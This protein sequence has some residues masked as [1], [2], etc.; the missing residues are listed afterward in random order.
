MCQYFDEQYGAN[1]VSVV[2]NNLYGPNDNFDLNTSHVIPA[3]IR[4][5]HTAKA[6]GAEYVEVWG[7][8]D[9]RR[10]FLYV[11]DLA[12]AL[13]FL[14]NN[15]NSSEPINVGTGEDISI[16]E[17]AELVRKVV[18]YEGK[19]VFDTTKPDGTLRRVLD[20][21][22]LK[23]LGWKYKLDL[24]IGLKMTYEAFLKQ[25]KSL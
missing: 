17:L 4:K 18:G 10:E 12:D 24:Q 25:L 7:S 21:S 11:D 14:M 16:K 2:P 3:L 22:K 15:Y 23:A 5:F 9:Q 13:L 8:G 20:V 6:A 1:F 19:I